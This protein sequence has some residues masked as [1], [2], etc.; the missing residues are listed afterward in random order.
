MKSETSATTRPLCFPLQVDTD[1]LD[2]YSRELGIVDTKAAP[3]ALARAIAHSPEWQEMPGCVLRIRLSPRPVL[4]VVGSFDASMESWLNGQSRALQRGC[5]QLRYVDYTQAEEDCTILAAQLVECLGRDGVKRFHFAPIP[6]GGL[7]VLG[8]LAYLLQLDRTQLLPPHPADVPLVIVDDCA[9]S[10]ARFGRFLASC[11]NHQVIF[12]PL[13]S[14]PDLRAAIA[15]REPR[16]VACLSARD[17]KD[18]GPEQFG[19]EYSGWQARWQERLGSSRYWIGMPDHVCFPW[20]EPDRSVWDPAAERVVPA[21]PI[22]PPERCLKNRLPAEN[23]G[24]PVQV[25]PQGRGPLRPSADA[26]FGEFQGQIVIGHLRTGENFGLAD[27]AAAMWRAIVEHGNLE[28]VLAALGR[29]Y[30]VDEGRLRADL[31]AFI[32]DLLARGLLEWSDDPAR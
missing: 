22:V 7:I 23:G 16:V 4:A 9:L 29:D 6:R 5:A 20:N 21:W 26:L 1:A 17:L 14:P 8:M 32:D 10:G 3:V 13:Y 15:S 19:A 11:T 27:V 2:H 28:E 24:I 12:A 30:E 25:Q 18:H 31:R